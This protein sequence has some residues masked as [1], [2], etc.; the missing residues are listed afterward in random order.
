MKLFCQSLGMPKI[1]KA[2][3]HR[4]MADVEESARHGSLCLDWLLSSMP[5]DAG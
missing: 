2:E 1:P 5:R 4:A 3:A